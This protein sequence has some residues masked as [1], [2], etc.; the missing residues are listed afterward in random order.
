MT[1]TPEGGR[2]REAVVHFF[3]LIVD[4]QR[5][6]GV[7]IASSAL[8]KAIERLPFDEK[9]SP[10]RYFRNSDDIL[11]IQWSWDLATCLRI[12]AV[13]ELADA[14][15][16]YEAEGS[17]KTV[18][19][20]G[21]ER[22]VA[23]TYCVI[24]PKTNIAGMIFSVAGPRPW[25]I[26]QYFTDPEAAGF[27][28]GIAFEALTNQNVREDLKRLSGIRKIHLQFNPPPGPSLFSEP[29]FDID[30]A[31]QTIT[32]MR[33]AATVTI[34]IDAGIKGGVT[35]TGLKDR[36]LRLFH[37]G[38]YLGAAKQL[39]VWGSD[40]YTKERKEINLLSDELSVKKRVPLDSGKKHL[41]SEKAF[42]AIQGAY[43][44]RLTQF[45]S[46]RVDD[47]E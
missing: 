8:H 6:P 36:L 28:Q 45:P 47:S 34:T 31:L 29:L 10:S 42:E 40:Q 12:R 14:S 43:G 1:R 20:G 35:L 16:A 4:D 22:W 17:Y 9:A 41:D 2:N 32:D 46:V 11:H 3:R 24:F 13:R 38:R 27:H 23:P 33:E 30:T 19:L 25:Q 37:Q 18:E 44:E 26:A 21:K 7:P 15:P 39:K 5:E